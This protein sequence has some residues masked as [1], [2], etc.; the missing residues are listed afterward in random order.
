MSNLADPPTAAERR[1]TAS[2]D[3]E[4]AMAGWLAP[5]TE[6]R[7]DLVPLADVHDRSWPH[8]VQTEEERSALRLSIAARGII[9]PLL[10]RRRDA[11]GLEVVCGQRRAEVARSLQLGRVPAI[12]R[13]LSDR[14]ALLVAAWSTL[15]RRRA[16][17]ATALVPA[18]L[19]AGL[20]IEELQTLAGRPGGAAVSF[21]IPAAFV[22]LPAPPLSPRRMRELPPFE[23]PSSDVMPPLPPDRL[24]AA[25]HALRFLDPVALAS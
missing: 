13:S 6:S 12:V 4:A 10:L 2:A 3:R 22:L 15:D 20:S 17:H 25:L 11:G 7:V 5:T 14:E 18:L 9:E 24:A 23:R 21:P 19:A 1:R 8:D 16:E